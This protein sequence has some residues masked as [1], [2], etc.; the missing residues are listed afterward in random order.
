MAK[1]RAG[2]DLEKEATSA[3]FSAGWAWRCS[4][5][6]KKQLNLVL[7]A[8]WVLELGLRSS[9]LYFTVK[10]KIA[11]WAAPVASGVRKTQHTRRYV[12]VSS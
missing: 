6:G 10:L 3:C 7:V 5:L 11:A 2:S 8:V 12:S 9:P 4:S 1:K